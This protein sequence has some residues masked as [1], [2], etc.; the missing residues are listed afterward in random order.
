MD[1]LPQASNSAKKYA[2]VNKINRGYL[3]LTFIFV[4]CNDG[5]DGDA[6]IVTGHAATQFAS[7]NT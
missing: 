4:Q 6:M 1:E 2:G 5:K 7:S 3:K